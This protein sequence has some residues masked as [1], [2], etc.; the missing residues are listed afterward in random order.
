MPSTKRKTNKIIVVAFILLLAVLGTGIFTMMSNGTQAYALSASLDTIGYVK[1]IPT[2]DDDFA[3]DRVIVTLK[4]SHS[5]VN[6]KYRLA[7]F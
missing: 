5:D 3:D 6:K 7:E 1:H 2:L 4:P